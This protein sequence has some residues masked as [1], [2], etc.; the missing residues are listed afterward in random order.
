[1]KQG[2]RYRILQ[3]TT[4]EVSVESKL[5]IGANLKGEAGGTSTRINFFSVELFSAKGSKEFSLLQSPKT[6]TENSYVGKDGK[7]NF[8]SGLSAETE[9]A[10]GVQVGAGVEC[11]ATM[12]QGALTENGTKYEGSVGRSYK[13]LKAE[14][15]VSSEEKRVNDERSTIK[16][17]SFGFGTSQGSFINFSGSVNISLKHTKREE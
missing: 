7:H 11:S 12:T 4:V 16:I 17:A 2:R 9:T 1:M 14:A 3:N 15:K 13:G 5:T 10:S 8:T 6:R